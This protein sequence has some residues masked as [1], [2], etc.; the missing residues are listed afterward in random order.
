MR[1]VIFKCICLLLAAAMLCGL[2]GCGK[3]KPSGVVSVRLDEPA[4]DSGEEEE[5]VPQSIGEA[6]RSTYAADHVF[7]L[8]A[9]LDD[10]FN[11]YVTS[12]AWNQVVGMLVYEN[13]VELDDSFEAVP[14]L[15]T[16]WTT[17]D[18][19]SWTFS[20]DTTRTFH[21]GDAVTAYDAVYSIQQA[22]AYGGRYASRFR[23]V[24]GIS[25]IDRESFAVTLT[26]ANYR[27]YQLLNVPCIEYY[28]GGEDTPPGT[29]PYKFSAAETYL[30]LDENHPKAAQMPLDTIY[31]KEYTAADDIL[32]A[33]EDSYIDLVINN[34]NAMSSLGYASTNITKYVD[35]T[36]MHYLGYNT[37]S[38][39]FTNP[40]FRAVITYAIDRNAIVSDIMGGAGV[41]AALPIHPDSL[42]Y[43]TEYA[44]S[45]AYSESGF[46]KALANIG[47]VDVDGDGALELNG[48]RYTLNFI[49]CSDSAVKVFAARRIAQEMQSCG[50][51]VNLRE[52]SYED[53]LE[54]LEEGN[55]DIYYGEVILCSDWDMSMFF[56]WD[57]DLNKGGL[58]DNTLLSHVKNFL[59]STDDTRAMY[60]EILYQYIGQ[61]APITVICFEKSEVL[62]HRGVLAGLSPTQDNVF[63]GMENW[64]VDLYG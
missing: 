28:T 15:V 60:G 54:N 24:K 25:A 64:T 33:F 22:M 7:S 50:L 12:S 5:K 59:A 40:V 27:F 51:S 9:M 52:L 56:E 58:S 21:N 55:F 16:A 1:S 20:V 34:S 41:A 37:T 10:S 49:V 4:E 2:C 8:N 19:I 39:V 13:L 57:G 44:A 42:L 45:L 46:A 43:P 31:L 14:N 30:T 38:G 35:T 18:G 47:A 53:Y 36:S 62:Y 32:Q 23:N 6:L 48:Q 26:E 63:Y 29:G 3:L 61:N 11:P 17:E